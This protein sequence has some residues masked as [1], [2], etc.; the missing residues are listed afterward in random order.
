MTR[1]GVTVNRGGF[2]VVV[3]I[4]FV[5][6]GFRALCIPMVCIGKAGIFAFR[7]SIFGLRLP[8]IRVD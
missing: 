2:T 4:V 5:A 8:P 1:H 7:F 3:D 6:A